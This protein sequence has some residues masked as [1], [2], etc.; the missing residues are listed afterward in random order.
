GNVGI[1]TT[2]PS[3]Q[4][5]TTGTLRF[6][7]FG[8]GTLTSDASGNITAASDER[9][10]NIEGQFSRGLSSILALNPIVYKWNEKSG[11]ETEHIY[12]GFSAQDV[13]KAIPE[14]V[15]Q[16]N[17]GFLSLSDRPVIAT[18]VNAVKELQSEIEGLKAKIAELEAEK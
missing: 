11:L 14:A 6:A 18:L 3:A 8:I 2:A 10:K 15:G 17:R 1:G 12:A 13:K 9:L 7:A 5:H 4:L 16:D